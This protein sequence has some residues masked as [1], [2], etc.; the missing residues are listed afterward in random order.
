V[1][2]KKKLLDEGLLLMLGM[3][4]ILCGFSEL[5]TRIKVAFI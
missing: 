1:S 3:C 4:E 5:T 2:V